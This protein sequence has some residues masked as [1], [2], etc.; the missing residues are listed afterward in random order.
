MATLTYSILWRPVN[1]EDAFMVLMMRRATNG[2]LAHCTDE[3]CVEYECV[4]ACACAS[5]YCIAVIL[6]KKCGN[7]PPKVQ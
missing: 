5:T 2:H 4:D 6:Q 1:D 7:S 3:V